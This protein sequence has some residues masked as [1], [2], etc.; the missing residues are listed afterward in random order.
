MAGNCKLNSPN[1]SHDINRYY[2]RGLITYG[3]QGYISTIRSDNYPYFLTIVPTELGLAPIFDPRPFEISNP[4]IFTIES[5]LSTASFIWNDIT[6]YLTIVIWNSIPI[7]WTDT[8]PG[9]ISYSTSQ[10]NSWP[11]GFLAGVLYN[12]FNSDNLSAY[13]LSY[14]GDISNLSPGQQPKLVKSVSCFYIP[15]SETDSWRSVFRSL[16]GEK[17]FSS[18]S[19]SKSCRPYPPKPQPPCPPCPPCPP[20]PCPT[21][22]LAC[23]L[24]SDPEVPDLVYDVFSV[25]IVP[26]RWFNSN[27]CILRTSPEDIYQQEVNWALSWQTGSHIDCGY[28]NNNDCSQNNFYDYCPNN[29]TCGSST[30]PS[31]CKGPCPTGSTCA[32]WPDNSYVCYLGTDVGSDPISTSTPTDTQPAGPVWQQVWFIVLMAII[33]VFFVGLITY[34]ITRRNVNDLDYPEYNPYEIYEAEF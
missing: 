19:N 34:L 33:I 8:K 27:G 9:V 17:I 3:Q 25:R 1:Q 30:T 13:W 12:T 4:T 24:F 10:A 2:T 28:T 5:Q 29:T 20:K 21:M 22:S 16:A 11:G 7:I 14:E 23:Q 6:Y 26:I 31:S 32:M 15:D 18:N